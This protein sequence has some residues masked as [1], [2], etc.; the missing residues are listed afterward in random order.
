M[1]CGFP[2]K[3]KRIMGYMQA[4]E[5]HLEEVAAVKTDRG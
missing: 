4:N 2:M 1:G 3:A 5:L